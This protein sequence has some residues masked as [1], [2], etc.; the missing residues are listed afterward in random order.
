MQSYRKELWFNTPSRRALINI[1]PE[2]DT[3]LRESGIQEGLA[4]ISAMHITAS[5][6]LTMMSPGCMRITRCGWKNLHRMRQPVNTST[7]AQ[8]RTTRTHT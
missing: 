4:L 3:C 2:V 1:T 7:I 6:L 5:V 8:V